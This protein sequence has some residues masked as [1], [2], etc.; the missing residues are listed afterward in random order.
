MARRWCLR[1]QVMI[2]GKA[3]SL[4]NTSESLCS[5]VLSVLSFYPRFGA[6]CSSG[7]SHYTFSTGLDAADIAT[8]VPLSGTVLN[9]CMTRVVMG[10]Y[11]E[12]LGV[13]RYPNFLALF[14]IGL[15]I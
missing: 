2:T 1:E 7:L 14:P 11:L 6:C 9:S 12:L 10:V 3:D 8:G 4:W 5:R 15:P 13:L